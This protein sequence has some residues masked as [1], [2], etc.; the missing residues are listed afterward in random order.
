MSE[1]LNAPI[2]RTLV[3]ALRLVFP[4]A[5]RGS[6]Y[7]THDVEDVIGT[8]FNIQIRGQRADSVLQQQFE[9]LPS[10]DKP[11]AL[12]VKGSRKD[13]LV[14]MGL[15]QWLAFLDTNLYSPDDEERINVGNL[16]KRYY[17]EREE[18]VNGEHQ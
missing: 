10:G 15:R 3:S 13:P 6:K 17:S 1:I 5:E 16:L 7:G 2:L 12:I 14:V 18:T 9:A 8:P 11:T 4:S